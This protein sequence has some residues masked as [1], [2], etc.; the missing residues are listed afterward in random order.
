LHRI[1]FVVALVLGLVVFL[2]AQKKRHKLPRKSVTGAVKQVYVSQRAV[3]KKYLE[4]KRIV[5]EFKIN[6]DVR[7]EN[8]VEMGDMYA[9]G[10]FPYL[11]PDEKVA[12]SCYDI[13]STCPDPLVRGNAVAKV[14]NLKDNPVSEQDQS[15][16]KMDVSYGE[17][18]VDI[19][20][21][22][23]ESH[24]KSINNTNSNNPTEIEIRNFKKRTESNLKRAT[25]TR[26][27]TR[28]TRERQRIGGGFQNT[29]DH[30]VTSATKTNIKRLVEDFK[31]KGR[32]L[33]PDPD[34]VEEAIELCR[35]K[36]DGDILADAHHVVVSLS[37]DEYSGTG[38]SQIQILD[39]VLWK[40]STIPDQQVRQNVRETLCK[41]LSSG[42]ENGIVVCGTG[43]VSRIISVFE[44]VLENIQK[45][46]SINL[47]EKEISH[48]A[49][50]VRDD[51]LT[52]VGPLGRKA[53]E[54]DNSVPE[55][56]VA[57]SNILK[58]RVKEEYVEKLNMKESIVNP[59]AGVYAD[60][61]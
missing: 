27:T 57:M 41:R 23:L 13:A 45:G 32:S 30:G 18:I 26:R 40:I 3:P 44:G 4:M 36:S 58:T 61:Y 5:D 49:L 52:S 22:Y 19:A 31:K 2:L 33:R 60:A 48:L 34:V 50:K 51:F 7:W 24:R 46:V 1:F 42:F 20:Q 16:D 11:L 39:M 14:M 17:N 37:P 25:T 8:L 10:F 35:E 38:V 47:V 12:L 56:A 53:Y 59:L 9:R 54:S 6:K 55:Y 29:H 28:E 21:T 43:K 15:G